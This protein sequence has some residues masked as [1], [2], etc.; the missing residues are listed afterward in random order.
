MANSE[1]LDL[2]KDSLVSRKK[3]A[4]IIGCSIKTIERA[5]QKGLITAIKFN[6]RL[7]RYRLSEVQSWI[8]SASYAPKR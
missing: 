1:E 8:N 2:N 4:Q 6:S 5:E 3:L 7:L